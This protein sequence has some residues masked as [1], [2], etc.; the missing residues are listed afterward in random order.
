VAPDLVSDHITLNAVCPGV[1]DTPMTVEALA[2]NDPSALGIRD[3][4]S[5]DPKPRSP[6]R[7]GGLG[8]L[9]G[10]TSRRWRGG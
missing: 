5:P 9:G 4:I 1:V 10:W 3:L 8:G 6:P 2:G 7:S